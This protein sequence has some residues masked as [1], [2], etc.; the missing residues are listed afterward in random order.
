M[1]VVV[2]LHA[3]QALTLTSINHHH[4]NFRRHCR[5]FN[6]K[7]HATT[8][9][10]HV[11]FTLKKKMKTNK[12][13]TTTKLIEIFSNIRLI[14]PKFCLL[15]ENKKHWFMI[16]N[17]NSLSKEKQ[18][19]ILYFRKLLQNS[20][21]LNFSAAFFFKLNNSFLFYFILRLISPTCVLSFM[22]IITKF[23]FYL[24]K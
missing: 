18:N 9:H 7:I 14:L 6:S 10:L 21:R 4:W 12:K 16:S 24:C 19:G 15:A 13:L 8:K 23:E 17:Y 11:H 1:Y 22:Q 5:R 3:R 2:R 20:F